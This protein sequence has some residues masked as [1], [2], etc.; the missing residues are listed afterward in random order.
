MRLF[1][2]LLLFLTACGTTGSRL[3]KSFDLPV[4]RSGQMRN[5]GTGRTVIDLV[6]EGPGQ[7]IAIL[8][9]DQAQQLR[10]GDRI[11]FRLE[12]RESIDLRNAS[13]QGARLTFRAERTDFKPVNLQVLAER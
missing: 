1:A 8:D 10:P 9:G 4:G 6:N 5:M 13:R 2:T 7:I 3:E 11:H 12:E